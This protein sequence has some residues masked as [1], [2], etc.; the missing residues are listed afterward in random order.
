MTLNT[1]N[2]PSFFA[3]V[4]T[5]LAILIVGFGGGVMMS[6]VLSDTSRKPN[7]IERQAAVETS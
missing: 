5:V 3:G 4:A 7:K 6:G 1:F 2:V